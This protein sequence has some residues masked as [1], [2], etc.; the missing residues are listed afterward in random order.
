MPT[1]Q[2]YINT[3]GLTPEVPYTPAQNEIL[4]ELLSSV[5]NLGTSQHID[6]H[7]PQVT[8]TQEE[9]ETFIPQYPQDLHLDINS[10]ATLDNSSTNITPSISAT[11]TLSSGLSEHTPLFPDYDSDL[12]TSMLRQLVVKW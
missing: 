10:L 4:Q 12:S 5:D 9:V 2:P 8:T 6:Y 1:P 7:S 11:T 3:L